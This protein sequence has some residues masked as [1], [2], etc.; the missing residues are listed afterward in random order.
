MKY[1]QIWVAFL[2]CVL[3]V[4]LWFTFNSSYQVYQWATQTRSSRPL[5]L[6]WGVEQQA[7]DRFVLDAS[8][9]FLHKGQKVEGNTIFQNERYRNKSTANHFLNLYKEKEWT[10]R[11]SPFQLQNST[12]NRLFPLKSCIYTA[13]V[14]CIMIY[15]VW[16]GYYVGKK[17]R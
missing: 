4:V 15:F 14:W 16:L 3:L 17:Y 9:I 11:Y 13:I 6:E 2:S 1:K 8:Y 12:I 5:E 7:S 10:V